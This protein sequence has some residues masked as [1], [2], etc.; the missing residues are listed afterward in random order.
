MEQGGHSQEQPLALELG[1]E[2]CQC[3]VESTFLAGCELVEETDSTNDD[4]LA[5]FRSGRIEQHPW[6]FVANHQNQ[7]IELN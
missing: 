6:L 5:A 2:A 7:L 4:C 1:E 3:I